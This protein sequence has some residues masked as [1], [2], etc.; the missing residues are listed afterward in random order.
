[1]GGNF[2]YPG[3]SPPLSWPIPGGIPPPNFAFRG[4]ELLKWDAKYGFFGGFFHLFPDPNRQFFSARAFGAREYL[5]IR[6][7]QE[8]RP[9]SGVREPVRLAAS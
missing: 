8:A 5:K 1:M 4:G 6:F 3:E 7:G 9:K 2:F